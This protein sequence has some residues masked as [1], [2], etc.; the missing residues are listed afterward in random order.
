MNVYPP[1]VLLRITDHEAKYFTACVTSACCPVS[2]KRKIRREKKST[3]W[4]LN[5]VFGCL[6]MEWCLGVCGDVG[7]RWKRKGRVKRGG[8][9]R[10]TQRRENSRTQK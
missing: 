10:V 8:I 4:G 3:H 5:A 9:S 1:F 7:G 2:H 6:M